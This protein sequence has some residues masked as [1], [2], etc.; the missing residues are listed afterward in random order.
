MRVLAWESADGQPDIATLGVFNSEGLPVSVLA[1]PRG[2]GLAPGGPRPAGVTSA[3][4]APGVG[5]GAPSA[6]SHEI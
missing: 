5:G 2:L 4:R 3:P 6:S 1:A